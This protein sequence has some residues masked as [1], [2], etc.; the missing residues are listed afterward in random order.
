VISLTSIRE[1]NSHQNRNQLFGVLLTS[2]FLT[3]ISTF[4]PTPALSQSNHQTLDRRLLQTLIRC[5][6]KKIPNPNRAN[7]TQLQNVAADC[8]TKEVILDRNGK[9]RPDANERITAI[10]IY[11]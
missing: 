3:G 9:L 7:Q 10:Y 5:V 6:E 2:I 11:F 4:F 1:Q 8:V